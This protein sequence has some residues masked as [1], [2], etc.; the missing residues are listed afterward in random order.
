MTSG[1]GADASSASP[2]V[3][4]GR[5]VLLVTLQKAAP[6][7]FSVAL[8]WAG[9]PLCRA[10]SAP[11]KLYD[12]SYALVIG[13]SNY[14]DP[15]KW[16]KIANAAHDA[17]AVAEFLKSAGFAVIVLPNEQEKATK[18]A[19]ER[20]FLAL[21]EKLGEN[22]RVVIFFA[23]HGDTKTFGEDRG[24]IIPY[25][26]TDDVTTFIDMDDLKKYS[27]YM[28][29][30]K[31]QLFIMDSCY[32]GTLGG[33]SRASILPG[34]PELAWTPK[35]PNA[36][37]DLVQPK[38]RERLT[39]GVKSREVLGGR[40]ASEMPSIFT[41]Q[42]L[43]TIFLNARAKYGHDRYLASPK[44]AAY[45]QTNSS[46]ERQAQ[47]KDTRGGKRE[48]ATDKGS[49]S[50]TNTTIMLRE[51]TGN[52]A[53]QVLT[54]GGKN[55]EVLDGGGVFEG[56]SLFTGYL[57]SALR[58]GKADTNNDGYITFKEL[59]AY[60]QTNASNKAQTPH[61]DT[62][63]GHDGG[64]FVFISP[65]S[66]RRRIGISPSFE[67]A[68]ASM[69]QNPM[70]QGIGPSALVMELT[71]QKERGRISN[72]EFKLANANQ[73]MRG[74]QKPS[75]GAESTPQQQQY[76]YLLEMRYF[77]LDKKRVLVE[78][79]FKKSVQSLPDIPTVKEEVSAEEIKFDQLAQ[80]ILLRFAPDA[81][82][83]LHL[84]MQPC[85]NCPTEIEDQ[86]QGTI[87]SWLSQINVPRIK[88]MKD[89]DSNPAADVQVVALAS[90]LPEGS[91]KVF[92]A[93]MWVHH[94]TKGSKTFISTPTDPT[95]WKTALK[96]LQERVE[97]Y[98]SDVVKQF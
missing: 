46:D 75:P 28:I 51:F 4:I 5:R 87:K 65:T 31:H 79:Q 73:E 96:E 55:Q 95:A 50:D 2:G 67:T 64:D 93:S 19:I 15:T 77:P 14:N 36:Q 98:I 90:V 24:Y 97:A 6:I 10:Q 91:G 92:T 53:R 39:R 49:E 42:F 52:K 32:G 47:Q 76:D 16:K 58:D 41:G 26:A 48:A 23:G 69:E 56:H 62:L 66:I 35:S 12:K 13:I 29:K 94:A 22:D 83:H 54:A 3:S 27:G 17:E 72:V 38:V 86:V 60:I 43:S 7:L 11:I 82:L 59:S 8:L 63:K 40:G 81:D 57:L 70:L 89:A 9:A 88:Y 20:A 1:A 85:A 45:A 80:K 74:S 33:G 34:K 78:A 25:D 68:D 44:L 21:A 71:D 37:R 30:A 84:V 18:R 61:D